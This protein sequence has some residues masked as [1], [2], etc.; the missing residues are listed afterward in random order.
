MG[1]L[2]SSYFKNI[3]TTYPIEGRYLGYGMYAISDLKIDLTSIERVKSLKIYYPNEMILFPGKKYPLILMVNGTG[4]EYVKYEATFKHLSSWG[5]IVA[6][7]DD[8]STG[9]GDSTIKTLNYML[10]LNKNNSSIFYNKIDT[11][12]IG[13]SGHSQ[14]GGGVINA[15]TNFPESSLFKCAYS[16][17]APTKPWTDTILAALKYDCSKVKIPTMMTYEKQTPQKI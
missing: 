7:N 12:K 1:N 15:I 14:G 4:F 10:D 16:A 6:G 9:F 8:P 2:K 3:Q 13:L 11:E 5:F 17:S